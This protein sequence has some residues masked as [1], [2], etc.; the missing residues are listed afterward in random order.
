MQNLENPQG[1]IDRKKEFLNSYQSAKRAVNRIELQIEELKQSKISPGSVMGDG[2]PRAHTQSDLS[3]YAVRLDELEQELRDARNRKI[4][5]FRNVQQAIERMDDE[6]EKDVLTYRHI[7]GK[8][9]K[10][11][12]PAMN[13]SVRTMYYIYQRALQNFESTK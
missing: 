13:C 1:E 4:T 11:I 7:Q 8:G 3:D 2:M 6:E 5:A 12:A 10:D 9:W